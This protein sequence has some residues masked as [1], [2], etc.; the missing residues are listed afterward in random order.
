MTIFDRYIFH[1]L[2]RPMAI[3]LLIALVIFVIERMLQLLDLVLGASGPAKVFL[4]II[5][6]LVPH[7][8]GM[9]LPLSLLLGVMVAFSRLGREGEIDAMQSA[10]VSL[11]RQAMAP[12]AAGLVVAGLTVGITG[13]LKPHARYAYEALVYTVGNV[14]FHALLRAGVFSR[15]G[16][17]TF[18]I[19]GIKPD[20]AGVTRVFL[21]EEQPDGTAITIAARD[22]QVVRTPT[23]QTPILR[24]F[25]GVRLSVA[26]GGGDGGSVS[27]GTANDEA[28]VSVLRFQE[29]R[30]SLS[31]TYPVFFRP[32]G[33]H[34]REMTLDE[35]WHRRDDAPEGLRRSDLVAEFHTRM[36]EIF[37][38]PLLP[39]LGIAL[40]LGRQRAARSAGIAGGL[41]VIIVYNQL[42]DFGKNLAEAGTA[43]P[44][45]SLWL[46][47]ALFAVVVLAMFWVKATRVPSRF[48]FAPLEAV[49]ARLR[50]RAATSATAGGGGHR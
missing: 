7:Y 36:V 50:R 22:G 39:L 27:E 49:V 3:A 15:F 38:I 18:L 23:H 42:I 41:I 25:D 32:R 5:G 12:F 24:L 45:V 33:V 34:E 19:E 30:E 14:A 29:L 46:P 47:F 21:Y 9:A 4:E 6:Y 16:D 1:H 26:G 43:P 37:T 2:L 20:G 11:W 40:A 44:M 13:Y 17:V 35:L 10:G 48:A 31:D 28:T 8:L